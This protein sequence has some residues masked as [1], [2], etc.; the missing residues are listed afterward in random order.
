[1]L[2]NGFSLLLLF[3]QQQ[4]HKTGFSISLSFVR[5]FKFH[6]VQILRFVVEETKKL[7][8]LISI[9]FWFSFQ[10][11]ILLTPLIII[12]IIIML[13]QTRAFV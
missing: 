13:L 2:R 4:Q 1:M 10:K 8:N 6:V 3:L 12:I 9:L 11:K 7:K 5:K